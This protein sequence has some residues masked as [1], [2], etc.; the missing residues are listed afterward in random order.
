M[1]ISHMVFTFFFLKSIL[2]ELIYSIIIIIDD[3]QII[4]K[5]F[6][7]STVLGLLFNPIFLKFKQVMIGMTKLNENNRHMYKKTLTS[8][9]VR[10]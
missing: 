3:N 1:F 9:R 4:K 6:R 10:E 2:N 8:K 7:C 5:D